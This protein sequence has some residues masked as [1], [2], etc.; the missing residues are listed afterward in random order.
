MNGLEFLNTI[1]QKTLLLF[2]GATML[3]IWSGGK[4]DLR[5]L[6]LQGAK[7]L[8]PKPVDPQ[9][10]PPGPNA[11]TIDVEST[12]VGSDR[13]SEVMSRVDTLASTRIWVDQSEQALRKEIAAVRLW[14]D[15]QEAKLQNQLTVKPEI[16][17]SGRQS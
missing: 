11:L 8:Q 14:A 10:Q 9:P 3:L 17:V 12:K 6:I 5:N 13:L 1:D 15:T 2:A 4:V 7:W 16:P